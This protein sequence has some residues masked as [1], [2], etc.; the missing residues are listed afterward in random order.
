MTTSLEKHKIEHIKL[1]ITSTPVQNVGGAPLVLSNNQISF[2]YDS[3]DFQLDGNNLQIKDSGISH[4]NLLNLEENDHPQYLLITDI[5]DTPIDSETN[6]PISSNW[7]YDHVDGSDT[8]TQYALLAGRSGGQTLKGGTD[9]GDDLTLQSTNSATKGSILFGTSA[10]DEVNNRLGIGTSTPNT[11]LDV[12]GIGTISPGLYIG[13]ASIDTDSTY[14]KIGS[15]RTD[16]GYSHIDLIG[17]TTYTDYGFRIIRLNAGANAATALYHRGT[18][19]L[20]IQTQEAASINF[21]TNNTGAL[22]IDSSQN[23][24]IGGTPSYRLDVSENASDWAARIFNDGNNANRYGLSIQCGADDQS[25]G[26]H[27]YLEAAD[28]D[29]HV[30]GYL[31][32]NAGT[33]ELIQASSEKR[34]ENIKDT[35]IDALEIL[36]NLKVRS[37]SRRAKEK[38]ENKETPLHSA[39]FIAEEVQE[40][41]PEMVTKDPNGDLFISE[42]RLIS[43]LVKGIQEQQKQIQELKSQ[44]ARSIRTT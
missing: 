12:Q 30:E 19:E 44:L 17:D 26:Q 14:L 32:V 15:S 29:G 5:D 23:V 6:A 8:H 31:R 28:G 37:F 13:D 25:S 24:G 2:S 33:F 43:V 20:A 1:D 22:Y 3:T 41:F 7:A 21:Y 9:S 4:S 35:K 42:S 11:T 18:G 16:N 10:Y 36:N 38:T 40:I 34:K 27:Y 39:G